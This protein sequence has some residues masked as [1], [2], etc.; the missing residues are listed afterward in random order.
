VIG[1]AA[2]PHPVVMPPNDTAAVMVVVI[3]RSGR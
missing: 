1:L 2:D 3:G